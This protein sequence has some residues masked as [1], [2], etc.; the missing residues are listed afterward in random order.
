MA[1]NENRII[2]SFRARITVVLT[3]LLLLTFATLQ[4]LN[5]RAQREVQRELESQKLVVRDTVDKQSQHISEAMALAVGSFDS[6]YFL[7]DVIENQNVSF[8]R[9]RIR[10]LIVVQASDGV[11]TDSSEKNLVSEEEEFPKKKVTLPPELLDKAIVSLAQKGANPVAEYEQ[12]G[13]RDDTPSDTYWV[14]V[15]TRNEENEF[16]YYWIAV[17]VSTQQVS[18]TLVE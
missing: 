2:F 17:V 16:T 3:V 10:H 15:K 18:N 4:Y 14:R 13:Q 8:D 5:L 9:E 6:S 11:I 1:Q 7:Y 12:D